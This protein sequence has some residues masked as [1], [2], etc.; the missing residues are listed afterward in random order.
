MVKA[1]RPQ[2]ERTSLG[3]FAPGVSGNPL[4]RRP[5]QHS[6]VELAR[7]HSEAALLI[8]VEIASNPK[9]SDAC[10]IAACLAVINRAHGVPCSSDLMAQM[11]DKPP[12]ILHIDPIDQGL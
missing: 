7:Q 1:L 6:I 2:P 11:G 4:G 10:R 9:T 5:T 8:L 12:I 3:R